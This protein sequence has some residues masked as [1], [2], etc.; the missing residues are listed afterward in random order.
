MQYYSKDKTRIQSFYSVKDIARR[1]DLSVRT[2]YN[3]FDKG[4]KRYKLGSRTYVKMSEFE[5]LIKKE[6]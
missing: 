2:I 3:L 5:L 1:Y 6:D 4:L